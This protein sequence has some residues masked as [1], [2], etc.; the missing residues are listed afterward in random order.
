MEQS[1]IVITISLTHRGCRI[2]RGQQLLICCFI[3]FSA[4]HPFK[5]EFKLFNVKD[6]I[7]DFRIKT[8]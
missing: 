5:D 3:F 4:I 8:V 6:V 7:Y 2:K 1:R